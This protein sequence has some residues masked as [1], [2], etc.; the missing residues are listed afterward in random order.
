MMKH[1]T[2]GAKLTAWSALTV[3]VALL[4]CGVGAVFFIH[5]EQIEAL[6]DQLRN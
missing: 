3:A 4:A 5:E 6:D 1:W 2:L